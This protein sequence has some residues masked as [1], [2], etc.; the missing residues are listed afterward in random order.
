MEYLLLLADQKLID[1]AKEDITIPKWH[2]GFRDWPNE[3]PN[4]YNEEFIQLAFKWTRRLGVW[5]LNTRT[6]DELKNTGTFSQIDSPTLKKLISNYYQRV[7]FRIN[8]NHEF[9]RQ[10]IDFW[11]GF[12]ASFNNNLKVFNKIC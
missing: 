9:N 8:D 7:Q 12:E 2:L 11:E 5:R 6:I 10:M 4:E 1:P 3:I